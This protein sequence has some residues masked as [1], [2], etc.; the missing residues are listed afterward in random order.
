MEE[1]EVR[2]ITERISEA[3]QN[4]EKKE[5]IITVSG[6]VASGKSRLTFLLKKF[7]REN[8]FE[9]EFDG[10][11]DHPTESNF[12]KHMSKNFEI[13]FNYKQITQ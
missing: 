4:M 1:K 13:E 3:K 12:D 10:N 8:G 7:L 11:T 9:V 5:L 6:Q 2:E